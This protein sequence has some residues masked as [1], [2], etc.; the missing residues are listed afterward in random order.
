MPAFIS[1]SGIQLYKNEDGSPRREYRPPEEVFHADSLASLA[2]A[3]VTRGHAGAIN[4]ANWRRHAIGVASDLP[5]AKQSVNG[6]D[7]VA[8]SLVI[9]DG[10]A[11]A[12][13]DAGGLAEV[14]AGYTAEVVETPG[15]TPSGEKYDAVQTNVRYN[16]VAIG[17]RGWARAGREARLRLDGNE[18]FLFEDS[19]DMSDPSEPKII[20]K[21]V[22]DGTEYVKGSDSHLAYLAAQ[23]SAQ[24]T[25]ADAAEKATGLEKARADALAAT[26]VVEQ[27]KTA[28][29]AIAKLV[30]DEVAFRADACKVLGAAF[31]FDGLTRRAVQLAAIEKLG[32]SA[33]VKQDA[34]DEFV[35][36]FLAA[37]VA[38]QPERPSFDYR[39]VTGHRQDG[40]PP[41]PAPPP[42]PAG[43]YQ[44]L[45]AQV[46]RVDKLRQDAFSAPSI[47]DRK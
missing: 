15:V 42:A 5:P 24:V 1:R 44:A 11:L 8:G 41:L 7:F 31:K 47:Y 34:S 25:R 45:E 10:A 3:T 46:N 39:Q 4:T 37:T 30:A 36:A 17:P 16:H 6:E 22:L 14:S 23:L 20:V 38:A 29:A 2:G 13:I 35:A 28:P 12:E 26:L 33:A 32:V 21:L 18:D 27:G 40:A 9:H 19:Q 43:S